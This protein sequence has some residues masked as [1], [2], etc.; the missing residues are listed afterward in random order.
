M[1]DF[2]GVPITFNYKLGYGI[3]LNKMYK[4][5]FYGE[6][7]LGYRRPLSTNTALY[8]T[9]FFRL[10][11]SAFEATSYVSRA[12]YEYSNSK[13]IHSDW[14]IMSEKESVKLSLIQFGI[15]IGCQ[16]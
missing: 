11:T 13:W 12:E 1:F 15:R 5:G 16:F 6:W 9:P 10:Q 8:L 4:S 2:N 14:E 7:A 3:S